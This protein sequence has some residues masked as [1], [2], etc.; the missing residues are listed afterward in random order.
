MTY[1]TSPLTEATVGTVETITP[2]DGHTMGG[3]RLPAFLGVAAKTGG[4]L[5]EKKKG[6]TLS[7]PDAMRQA[8]LDFTVTLENIVVPRGGMNA[9][10]EF[11][12]TYEPMPRYR[13]STGNFRDGR[14]VPFG[15][16]SARYQPIQP[17]EI[18]ELGDSVV[19]EAGGE[20]AALG[21]FGDP[22]GS[23]LYMAFG[24]GQ[25]Q[26]GGQ[27]RHDLYLT[28]IADQAGRGGVVAQVAP[29]RIRCTNQTSGI[30]GRRHAGRYVLRHTAGAKARVAEIRQALSLTWGYVEHYQQEAEQLLAQP[31]ST[32]DFL[33]WERELFDVPADIEGMTA[34]RRTMIANR[35][36]TLV[37][38][39]NGPTNEGIERTRLAAA[40]TFI[41]YSDHESIVR[42][43]DPQAARWERLMAGQTEAQ[44]ARAWNS[45]LIS[46]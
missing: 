43:Q 3:D 2:W 21:M 28:I 17:I 36:E 27:D 24:L 26:V 6:Q 1:R 29:I 34:N 35:D 45:L 4:V 44:K 18:A 37:R 14:F 23:K 12:Y 19:S 46:A 33:T 25:F 7:V 22:I 32:D 16:V 10:G 5:L 40:Q 13:A 20:L 15:P 8:D 9:D 38:I 30:F 11:E 42:G 39:F 31:M 41:E